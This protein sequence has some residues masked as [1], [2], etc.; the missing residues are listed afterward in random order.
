MVHLSYPR[1]RAFPLS[2]Y[3]PRGACLDHCC[4][5]YC[6]AGLSPLDNGAFG[7]V[8]RYLELNARRLEQGSLEDALDEAFGSVSTA[9]ARWCFH[10]CGYYSC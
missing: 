8:T 5:R 10:R 4:G 3:G 9:A 6:A 7:L 1:P 2:D